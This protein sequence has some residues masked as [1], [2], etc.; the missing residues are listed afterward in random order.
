MT[1]SPTP[2]AGVRRP[3]VASLDSAERVPWVAY[4]LT[5]GAAG[6]S[7]VALFFLLVDTV[8]G[9]PFWTPHVLGAA[10]FLG[11]TPSLYTAPDLLLVLAYTAV[12]FAVFI[13]LGTP[14]AFWVLARL[15]SA[16]GRGRPVLLALAL[17]TAFEVVFLSLAALFAPE[18]TGMLTL[19]RVASANALA[20]VA[21]SATLFAGARAQQHRGRRYR[22]CRSKTAPSKGAV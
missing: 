8:M 16:R 18:L 17:F 9:R 19:G 4:G 1:T 3:A 13:G 15:P 5:A 11:E 2:V 14:A 21:M 6:A 22:P 7:C 10:L 12:H 20:A